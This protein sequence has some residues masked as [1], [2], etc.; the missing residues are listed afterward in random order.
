MYLMQR[1]TT[2]VENGPVNFK[3]VT[4]QP[5]G[6]HVP[7]NLMMFADALEKEFEGQITIELLG[8]PEVIGP[9]QQPEAVRVGQ[10]DMALTSASFYSN[11]SA[12]SHV[13]MYS[14]QTHS[15]LLKNG[16]YDAHEKI[17]EEIGFAYLGEITF[18]VPFFMFTNF[19]VDSLE[20][21]VGKKIRV[22]P[23]MTPFVRSLGAAPVLMG[24]HEI[25]SA[26]ERGVVDGFV[27]N[28]AG[29]VNVQSWHEVTKYMIKPAFYR[30]GLILLV[31]PDSWNRLAPDL[32]QQIKDF[33][34]RVW[35]P[36]PNGG[37]WFLN[38]NRE[39]TKL[40]E[41]S[42]VEV[43]QLSP[44]MAQEYLTRAYESAWQKIMD[45]EPIRGAQLKKLL[46]NE[47][48]LYH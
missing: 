35:D 16:F 20:D 44:E 39:E 23:A 34:F 2:I 18:D 47:A 13:N 10:I 25:Y 33:K 32:Q 3:V 7:R 46:V 28:T 8:G 11:M 45:D 40:I 41:K 5:K 6:K 38:F 42:G 4:I 30:G 31:N 26:M 37:Q 19:R 15:A 27:M 9:F 24:Q 36:D 12:L 17:H 22:F 1:P 43:I 14:N 29:F 21:F 48:L